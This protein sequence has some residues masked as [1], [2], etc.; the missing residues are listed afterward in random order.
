MFEVGDLI[1]S[2]ACWIVV[3]CVC[4]CGDLSMHIVQLVYIGYTYCKFV[5]DT[6]FYSTS[7]IPGTIFKHRIM[8]IM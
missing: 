6:D 1:N 5:K 8:G 7:L 3:A 4:W 2:Q